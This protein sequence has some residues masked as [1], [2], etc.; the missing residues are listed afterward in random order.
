MSGYLQRL[1]TAAMHPPQAIHPVVG[2]VYGAPRR[3]S[4]I[5][6]ATMEEV[7]ETE[8][9]SESDQSVRAQQPVEE[10]E[11]PLPQQPRRS[12]GPRLKD[13]LAVRDRPF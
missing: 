4:E 5:A 6:I 8:W 11:T 13:E 3:Q 2:S 7:A 9:P 10:A 12:D 1:V